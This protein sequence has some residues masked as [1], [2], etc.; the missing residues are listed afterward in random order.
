MGEYQRTDFVLKQD[1]KDNTASVLTDS[2]GNP[3]REAIAFSAAAL[4]TVSYNVVHRQRC[5]ES[6]EGIGGKIKPRKEPVQ[7][8]APSVR[9]THRDDNWEEDMFDRDRLQDITY[10]SFIQTNASSSDFDKAVEAG[11][12]LRK[13]FG[14]DSWGETSLLQVQNH[15]QTENSAGLATGF[16]LSTIVSGF[17]PDAI[18]QATNKMINIM[19]DDLVPMMK[20]LLAGNDASIKRGYIHPPAS[21]LELSSELH[22]RLGIR[23]RSKDPKDTGQT[24][25]AEPHGALAVAISADVIKSTWPISDYSSDVFSSRLTEDLYSRL[26]SSSSEPLAASVVNAVT[27]MA[28]QAL[29]QTIPPIITGSLK[30]MIPGY[31]VQALANTLTNTLTR[32]VGHALT[33]TLQ[34]SLLRAPALELACYQCHYAQKDCEHCYS[35]GDQKRQFVAAYYAHWYTSYYSDYYSFYFTRGGGNEATGG[36]DSANNVAEAEPVSQAPAAAPATT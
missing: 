8:G 3:F 12:E 7:G 32:S 20:D 21:F 16:I 13:Q 19:E 11:W 18:K 31:V 25:L 23:T 33:Q 36:E 30:R 6:C 17:L 14:T 15:L 29:P 34:H 35:H 28:M 22:E 10:T 26:A 1:L 24:G 4:P 9:Q 27:P 2:L 5:N